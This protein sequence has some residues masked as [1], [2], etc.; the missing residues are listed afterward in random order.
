MNEPELISP[1]ERRVLACLKLGGRYEVKAIARSLQVTAMAVRY[2]LAV[3]EKASLVKTTLE[4]GGVGRPHTVYSL[5]A[6]ADAFFPKEYET[7]ASNFIRAI[8]EV[9]GEGKLGPLFEHMKKARVARYSRRM[10]GKPLR[11]RVA[12][13]A[14]IMTQAGY[15]AKWRQLNARTFEI[16]EYNCAIS[17]VAQQC[18]HACQ[19]EL[20]MLRELLNATVSRE[21]H[22]VAGD[23]TCR[24]V[25]RPRPK[26][27]SPK[28]RKRYPV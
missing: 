15:M 6:S 11:R 22:M 19:A 12:E 20:D 24:Y 25:I 14:K 13:M 4:R 8:A 5:S 28:R 10:A 3:L 16:T 1:A 26:R 23:S 27:N 21:E 7:L 18:Q 2:H 9:D 17:C